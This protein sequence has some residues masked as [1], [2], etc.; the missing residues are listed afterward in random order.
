MSDV[1]LKTFFEHVYPVD[2]ICALVRMTC[3][4]DKCEFA[5]DLENGYV[6]YLSVS[7]PAELRTL[8]LS[9]PVKA[10]H[11]GAAY[12]NSVSRNSEVATNFFKAEI[13]VTDYDHLGIEPS[14][15]A[16]CDAAWPY[17]AFG[18]K[19]VSHLLKEA[20]TLL[21]VIYA[22]SG[23]RG[24]HMWILDDQSAGM[25]Q[26]MRSTIAGM[27]N[28]SSKPEEWSKL[29]HIARMYSLWDDVRN[30]FKR[31]AVGFGDHCPGIFETERST[32]TFCE[33][34]GVEDLKTPTAYKFKSLGF[35]AWKQSSPI[36]R[37]EYLEMLFTEAS[38]PA[39]VTDKL[40]TVMC[41]YVWPRLDQAVTDGMNH[42]LKACFL[43][44]PKTGR[45]AFPLFN[46][47][48]VKRFVP[49]TTPTLESVMSD[50]SLQDTIRRYAQTFV[51]LLQKMKDAP[52]FHLYANRHDGKDHVDDFS[53]PPTETP[54]VTLFHTVGLDVL[55]FRAVRKWMLK[56]NHDGSFQIGSCY[57]FTPQMKSEP[58][59]E[60]PNGTRIR[61]TLMPHAYLA[62]KMIRSLVKVRR[63]ISA[64]R[65]RFL[66][67]WVIIHQ[68]AVFLAIRK[69][70]RA[71]TSQYFMRKRNSIS[72]IADTKQVMLLYSD[73]DILSDAKIM[74][75]F[76]MF[77]SKRGTICYF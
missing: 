4:L 24:L 66:N 3:E 51:G 46:L 62:R 53:M 14:N 15:L 58:L 74:D 17:V 71:A 6:R 22:Y 64:H 8:L 7:S 72:R 61:Y 1:L 65:V 34:L 25:T 28:Y 27:I 13:D 26:W 10:L 45:I 56:A 49:A 35:K 16:A 57:G 50:A 75:V 44:H 32:S 52:T 5:M 68:E 60:M 20:F 67:K 36:K 12:Q 42:L 69:L 9:K 54:T 55:S 70:S 11:I 39:W 47:Q 29:L 40:Y 30:F 73:Q 43:P 48:E 77:E 76:N 38:V 18:A 41:A 19:V 31:A 21:N 63:D 37:F 33:L 59:M 23:R 2:A